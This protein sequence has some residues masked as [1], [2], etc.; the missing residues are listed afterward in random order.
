[1]VAR[2]VMKTDVLL[3]LRALNAV[4]NCTVILQCPRL[5]ERH[6]HGPAIRNQDGARLFLRRDSRSLLPLLPPQPTKVLKVTLGH[7]RD[8]L[9]AEDSHLKAFNLALTLGRLN[10]R[11]LKVLKTL[12]DDFVGGNMLGNFASRLAV[13]D[14]FFWYQEL[15]D[16]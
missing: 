3:V 8:V 15:A 6:V 5:A 12:E 7:I 1:M 4:P 2:N 10:A 9:P 14:E 13:C 11:C 16:L